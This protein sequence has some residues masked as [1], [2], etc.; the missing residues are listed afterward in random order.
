MY[1]WSDVQFLGWKPI[2]HLLR[3]FLSLRKWASL[4]FRM[5][6]KSLLYTYATVVIGVKSV[7][8]FMDWGDKA[9]VPNVGE[10]T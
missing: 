2:L 6:Q 1:I 9:F 4:P 8:V 5:L 10:Y 3:T 7:S